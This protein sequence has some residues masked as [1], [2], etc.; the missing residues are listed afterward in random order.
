ERQLRIATNAMENMTEAV[1]ITDPRF[2]VV[3]V[4]GAFTAITGYTQAE[5]G[6]KVPAYLRMRA[7]DTRK[8]RRIV[9]ALQRDGRWL[10]ELNNVR[11]NGET[12]P[13]RLSLA[14]VPGEDGR[15][16][17]YV[18]IFSDNSAFRDYENRLKHLANHDM[19]T[20]LPNR[21]AFEEASARAIR[22]AG[23]EGHRLALL[24]IDLD[25][26]KPVNDNYGH[27]AGDH[28]LRTVSQRICACLRSTDL[29]ARV[30]GDEFNVLLD[31]LSD[32]RDVARL[33]RT[34]LAAIAEPIAFGEHQVSLSASI[35]ISF[36][37]EDATEFDALVTHADMA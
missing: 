13:M 14:S 36:Y 11:K 4:N 20:Q 32:G 8:L 29:V 35:G 6:G 9:R 7:G 23:R 10:G 30:G 33:A 1:V 27:A 18:G 34:L 19:L 16:A 3:S 24:F 25:G 2:H 31:E 28:V 12:Y 21:A 22:R 17:H 5:V 26:F 37:P 15:I